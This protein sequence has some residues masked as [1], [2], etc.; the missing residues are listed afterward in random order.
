MPRSGK[1]QEWVTPKDK[2]DKNTS[3]LPRSGKI[4]ITRG[5][6]QGGGNGIKSQP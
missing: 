6:T 5:E 3:I 1:Y 2:V 4:S